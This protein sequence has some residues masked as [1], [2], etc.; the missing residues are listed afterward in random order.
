MKDYKGL[1]LMTLVFLFTIGVIGL[2]SAGVTTDGTITYQMIG[3]DNYT[4]VTFL[5]N[6]TFNVSGSL[7]ISILLV[8]G[9]GG[10]GDSIG[11]AAGGG[12][13][14]ALIYNNSYL[15][16]ENGNYNVAVG[17]GG[18]GGL[19]ASAN[20]GK[21]SNGENSLIYNST[22]NILAYGGGGGGC[23]DGTTCLR[24]M[25][26][27]SN[28]G[29]GGGGGPS[30]GEGNATI[31][32]LGNHGGKNRGGGGGIGGLGGSNGAVNGAV[33][34]GAGTYYNITGVWTCYAGGGASGGNKANVTC[35]G[36][37][38]SATAHA[39]A[40]AG[41]NGKGGGGGSRW[42]TTSGNTSGYKGGDGIVIIRF[43]TSEGDG[44]VDIP[45]FTYVP[46]NMTY[47]TDQ[48][49]IV[50]FNS[51]GDYY[52][53]NDTSNFKLFNVNG[54]I[55]NNTPLVYGDYAINVT[56]NNS[57]NQIN[58]TILRL[59]VLLRAPFISDITW[60]TTG[61]YETSTLVYSQ[62]L[63]YINV[64]ANNYG[65]TIPVYVT[66]T[67]PDGINV[68]NNQSMSN[69][70]ATRYSYGVSPPLDI[71]LNKAGN[72]TINCSSFN[73]YSDFNSTIQTLVVTK[74]SQTLRDGWYG[75]S[76]NSIMNL[77]AIQAA[78][79]YHYEL[80]EMEDSFSTAETNFADMLASIN[81]SRN[82]N[83]KVGINYI[84]DFDITDSG[85][86]DGYLD[87][88]YKNFTELVNTPYVDTVAYISFEIDTPG[89]YSNIEM[90]NAL[91]N[92]SENV[93]AVIDNQFPIYSKNYSNT[94]YL[95][96]AYI[97]YTPLL[98]ITDNTPDP[99]NFINIQLA[100]FKGWTSLSR[101]YEGVVEPFKWFGDLFNQRV[102]S[103]LRGIPVYTNI[104]SNVSVL[105]N[106]D[107]I[108][109]N[110]ASTSSNM[111]INVSSL[112][113]LGKDA[114]DSTEGLLVKSNIGADYIIY[115][116]IDAYNASIIYFDDFEHIQLDELN[117]GT[118][119]KSS[120]TGNKQV[121]YTNTSSGWSDLYDISEN[122][123]I[124]IELPDPSYK[125]NNFV[126]FYGWLNASIINSTY[127]DWGRYDKIIIADKNDA[128]VD[129]VILT[130]PSTEVYGYISVFDYN[131]TNIWND[132][133]AA[134]V[135]E[136]IAINGSMNI[137]VD[138]LDYAVI[139]DGN[140]ETRMKELIDYI[141]VTKQ[142]KAILNTYTAYQDFATWGKAGVMK[143]SCVQRWN[144]ASA[145]APTSY[146]RESWSLELNKSSWYNAHN[147][148]VLCQ[149]FNNRSTDGTNLVLNYTELQDIYFASKVL[150]YD[151]FYL[152]QPDFGYAHDERVYDVGTDLDRT[153][154]QLTADANTYYR[155]YSNGIVY[156]NS[157]SGHG[158]IEDGKVINSITTCFYMYNP[159]AD[160]GTFNFNIN[161]RDPT[162]STG[163][164]SYVKDWAA[165]TWKWICIDTTNENPIN[166]MYLIEGW[167]G[168]HVTEANKGMQI[169]NNVSTRSGVHS[170]W[171]ASAT[172]AFTAYEYG[173]NWMVNISV[174][175]TIRASVDKTS[176]ITQ[177]T[178]VAGQY[179][180][181]T[182]N[183][184]YSFPIEVWSKTILVF[185]F[186]N[187]TYY[188]VSGA[189]RIKTA[190]NYTNH[191]S[192]DTDN[193]SW[194]EKNMTPG[195]TI[196][197][198]IENSGSQTLVRV[199]TYS[200]SDRE[201][202]IETEAASV[203]LRFPFSNQNYT[204]DSVTFD[205]IV[206]DVSGV[207]NVSLYIDGV[208]NE[209]D[210]SG[211]NGSYLFNKTLSVGKHNWTIKSYNLIDVPTEATTI[212]FWVNTKPYITLNS[213]ANNSMQGESLIFNASIVSYYNIQNVSLYIDGVIDQT[214]TSG[215][216]NTV[217]L[218]TKEFSTYSH[219]W[220]IIAFSSKG[221]SNQSE[222]RTFNIP[223]YV[224]LNS[225]ANNGFS[226]NPIELNCSAS[227][228][229][230][231]VLTNISLW[232]NSTGIWHRNQTISLVYTI[233]NE[234]ETNTLPSSTGY[235]MVKNITSIN[236]IV[237]NYSNW[238]YGTA[239]ITVKAYLTYGLQN[240]TRVNSS[241][242]LTNEITPQLRYY[243]AVS[244]KY[245]SFIE[246]W[247]T[248]EEG[249]AP[250]YSLEKND[251]VSYTTNST[252]KSF[253][254]NSP[255]N[256]LWNCEV[257]DSS[258]FTS[259][260]INWSVT[261]SLS[262]N[263]NS[264]TSTV[265]ETEETFYWANV[266]ASVPAN[267]TSAKLYIGGTP[268][269]SVQSGTI[270]NVSNIMVRS[271]MVGNK[272]IIWGINYSGTEY[273]T[274]AVYQT[275]A[276]IQMGLCNATLLVSYLNFTFKDET[277][278]GWMNATIP[279]STFVYYL[280]N[281]TINKTLTY[282]QT[283]NQSSYKFCFLP[284]NKTYY[285]DSYM[286][287]KL[288]TSYPQ[289]IYDPNLTAY[290][291]QTTNVT[292]Y[293]L[294]S[295]GGIYVTFQVVNT[296][297]QILSGVDVSATRDIGGVITEVA[298]GTTGADGT[299]TFW[300]NP[301]FSHS[302]VFSKTGYN[303]YSTT[304]TPTQSS[305][306]IT[307]GSSSSSSGG[308][309]SDYTRGMKTYFYPKTR[310]LSND[311]SY[312]FAFNLTSS[313][314]DL[315]SFG[316]KLRLSDGTIVGSD[317]STTAGTAASDSY[318]VNNQ[319]IIY[320]DYYWIVEGVYTNGSTSWVVSNSLNTDWSI[321]T[322]FDDADRYIDSGIFG[323]DNFGR[324]VIAFLILFLLVG[325]IGYKFGISNPIFISVLTFSVVFF[326]DVIT[327]LIPAVPI[328]GRGIEHLI[329][330][331]AGLI[332]LIVIIL[333]GSR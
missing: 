238:I 330:Y 182:L 38:G 106:G 208:L 202:E 254:V 167:M 328:A 46:S 275:I 311:T 222:T 163:E 291:N 225:P 161:N 227:S 265:Y 215:Y 126:V 166:G 18:G 171:D 137:F 267:L 60:K 294:D 118:L 76:E 289:R 243:S 226:V 52:S 190:I 37:N 103:Q 234:T 69:Q 59:K 49:Y 14:G 28:G 239:V 53:I 98:Y 194:G 180:N 68:I 96:S 129:N 97:T 122:R 323:I 155:T 15:L 213:P 308:S 224:N 140:F 200:L 321:K 229:T 281:G 268:Y 183:S 219:N 207:K 209:T 142:R 220:S 45:S 116:E 104:S 44:G 65:L 16:K 55:L 282:S 173:K 188:N 50:D 141:Q 205:A 101:I 304:L 320:M 67:D 259:N 293:L 9:G 73:K 88:L 274:T 152:S 247:L 63:D 241:I 113:V 145:A 110:N 333:E 66:L 285:V 121:N 327:G 32:G 132:V 322:F 246:V 35:G 299:V 262:L 62:I 252:T 26:S 300:M 195:N 29:S 154:H 253:I 89:D 91:N 245:V 314:W 250:H 203:T 78:S 172:D 251:S 232:T 236:G 148:S 144:G 201:F 156:Y 108:V 136:W 83:I 33:D 149:A 307:M 230:A 6:G 206:T 36:G 187:L 287:Y 143:E 169:G 260:Y 157:T 271:S 269:A 164:Y 42:G 332:A 40:F 58:W 114:W 43:L 284:G 138:G 107:I 5:A 90:A 228:N 210:T 264:Y 150:G 99:L 319:T 51:T 283:V 297:D 153:Y 162:G 119:Y 10:S 280:G 8:A 13:A 93:S 139:T 22:E 191:T 2:A 75:Y 278:E 125:R 12:G 306:T 24:T 30:Y 27:G 57:A 193:P 315:D 102:V 302:M 3:E 111:T 196:K 165:G 317:S 133:K 176:L 318:D 17:R 92:I 218:F 25:M 310:E 147:V 100:L 135:N 86:I 47:Y 48:E 128:G 295:T 146:T 312:T 261:P 212:G 158:W 256:I 31:T 109:F 87:D 134:Q 189:S 127:G 181:I 159:A 178:G 288:G 79:L 273:N 255:N 70:T 184:S 20:L 192:C 272:S 324:L 124:Q 296:A 309:S 298:T 23:G 95:D 71:T 257:A 77:A 84:L 313:Y 123:D 117:E 242:A 80:F 325:G 4:I 61:G 279:T 235:K 270:W 231:V 214:N 41:E 217:Y 316:F 186:K 174:S 168:T 130:S 151:Y 244:N 301:D 177:T 185:G 64:T 54:T 160:A 7:N 120:S 221:E 131:D 326:L 211:N 204:N 305:Y 290:V 276:P 105:S 34:G 263:E 11:G 286:Q 237:S 72:W 112:G 175:Q 331:V 233:T 240:G 249:V 170:F 216:N 197:A 39:I 21:G 179:Y 82:L 303:T 94:T 223:L 292:L 258:N 1:I 81:N 85:L 277:T 248:Y 56:I 266:T 74:S 19:N 329:T 198:C 115:T 199:A